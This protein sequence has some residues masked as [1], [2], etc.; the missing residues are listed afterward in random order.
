M[1]TIAIANQ[2]GGVGKTTT[3]MNLGVG[4]ARNGKN[5]LLIDADPQGDL[6]IALGNL[7]PDEMDAA[8]PSLIA[9]QLIDKNTDVKEFIEHHEEGVDYLSS[10]IELSGIEVSLVNTMRREYVLSQIIDEIK[11]EYDYILI[12]CSPSIGMVTINA[13]VAADSV[14]IPVQ[15]EYLPAK[16]L[17]QLIRTIY[18]AKNNH[19][20][21]NLKIE[22]ILLTMVDQRTTLCKKIVELIENLYG[23]N[24]RIFST[25]IPKSVRASEMSASGQSIF[26]YDGSG[27]VAAAYDELTKEIISYEE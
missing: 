13:L 25:R 5:V 16:G 6:S 1:K 21:P 19:L 15:A 27:K 14:I 2:K 17:E 7:H 9:N 11:G 3:T 4:L 18:K 24:I 22:G 26:T 8:L 20:N 23:K 10:N 12:D